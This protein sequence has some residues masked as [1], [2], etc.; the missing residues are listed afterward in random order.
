[1]KKYILTALL[2]LA[3]IATILLFVFFFDTLFLYVLIGLAVIVPVC[4]I[5]DISW[6]IVTK[7]GENQSK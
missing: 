7:R 5:V 6:A 2:S 1:M 4:V 3:I